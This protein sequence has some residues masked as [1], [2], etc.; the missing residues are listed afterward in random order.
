MT[1]VGKPKRILEVEPVDVPIEVPEKQ[2][3]KVPV[4]VPNEH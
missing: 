4:G 1:Q 2:P 3:E